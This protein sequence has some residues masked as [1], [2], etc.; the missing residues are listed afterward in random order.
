V[1]GN[2]PPETEN[3]VPEIE[4][5]LIVT[6]TVPLDVTVTDCDTEVPT[7]TFP[8]EREVV[9]RLNDGVAAFNCR[10]TLF[11]DELALAVSVAVCEVVTEATLAVKA[12]AVAPALTVTLPGTVTALLLLAKATLWPVDGAEVFNDTVQAVVPVPVNVLVPHDSALTVG[13]TEA[14][15]PL[16]LTTAVGAVL[17]IVNCPVAE[18][19]EVGL[20]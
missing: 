16:R 13:A 8:N 17:K 14:P 4:S 19:A 12:A 9:F 2:A 1:T 5:E 15:V 20:N 11:D 3:P 7:E 6:A 10:A 18:V